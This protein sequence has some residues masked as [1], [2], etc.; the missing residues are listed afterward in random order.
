MP[1]PAT[2]GAAGEVMCVVNVRLEDGV[3]IVKICVRLVSWDAVTGS[4]QLSS[5]C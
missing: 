2:L 1:R 4:Q 5:R 3:Q